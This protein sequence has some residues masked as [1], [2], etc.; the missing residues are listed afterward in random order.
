VPTT[1]SLAGRS[2]PGRSATAVSLVT[3]IGD[4]AF[5]LGPPLVGALAGATSFRTALVPVVASTAAIALLARFA[6]LTRNGGLP[7]A[8]DT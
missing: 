5:V 3:T 1:L 7:H 4:S 2:A 6:P 8:D